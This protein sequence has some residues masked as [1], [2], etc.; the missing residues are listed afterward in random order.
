MRDAWKSGIEWYIYYTNTE[1]KVRL[2][3]IIMDIKGHLN[4]IKSVGELGRHY[5]EEHDL[6]HQAV[7]R[8]YPRDWWLD[9]HQAEDVAYGLRC[10]ELVTGRCI[11]LAKGTPSRWVVETVA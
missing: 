9:T 8:L 4:D 11:D 7:E 10:I 2:A 6:A 1:R 5:G 3:R